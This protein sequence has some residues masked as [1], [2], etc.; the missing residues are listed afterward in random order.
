MDRFGLAV[1]CSLAGTEGKQRSQA[2]I[3]LLQFLNRY[4][5][6]DVC[7]QKVKEGKRQVP[8]QNQNVILWVERDCQT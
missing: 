8:E 2:M 4:P 3:C 6:P 1:N 7:K 5:A